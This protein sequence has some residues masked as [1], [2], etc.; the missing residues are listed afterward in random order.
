MAMA[1]VF[2]ANPYVGP[3]PFPP[4]ERIYGR[5]QEVDRLLNLLIAERIVLL[6]SPSGAGKTSLI[7]SALVPALM[8]AD[9]GVLPVMRVS[10]ETQGILG[11]SGGAVELPPAAPPD[12]VLSRLLSQQPSA[13]PL[14]AQPNSARAVN[15]YMLSALL[16]LEAGMPLDRQLPLTTLAGLTLAEYLHQRTSQA[17]R[18]SGIVLIFDQFE[19]ILTIDPAN[20]AAKVGFFRQVGEALRDR[21]YWALFALREDYLAGLDPY[22][23]PIPTR[24]ST[25]FR[26]DLLGVEAARVA[27]QRPSRRK[28]VDFTDAAVAKLVNDLRNIRVQ[29][30]DGSIDNQPG[31]YVEPVQ[32]QV[33]CY[34][35]WEQLARRSRLAATNIVAITEEDLELVGDVNS[36]LAGYY[37]ERVQLIAS[38]TGV[39]ERQ[40]RDWVDQKL[41][42]EQST[43]GQVLR[44]PEASQGLDNRAIALLIDWHLVRAE[45]RGDVIWF[46]LTHDRLIDP[47]RADNATWREA[48]LSA[49]QRQAAFWEQE[50]RPDGLLLRDAALASAE[51]W[52]ATAAIELTAVEQAFLKRCQE[53]RAAIARERRTTRIIRWLGIGATVLAIVALGAMLYALNRSAA[54]VRAEGAALAAR[55]TSEVRRN[56]ADRQRQVAL[57][58]QAQMLAAQAQTKQKD[59]PDLGL[60]LAIEAG[61]RDHGPFVESVLRHAVAQAFVHT[62][63]LT[64]TVTSAAFSPDGLRMLTTSSDGITELRSA[65]T[66]E[67][68]HQLTKKD[69]GSWRAVF[70]PDGK[71][72]IIGGTDGTAHVWDVDTWKELR[73]LRGHTKLIWGVAYSQD[74][75]RIA[76]A[77]GDGTARVWDAATGKE[78]RVLRGHDNVVIGVAFSADSQR[79]VT[80]SRD[81]TA[82]VWDVETGEQLTVLRGHT[83]VVTSAAFSPDS[84][85]IVTASGDGMARVWDAE[86]GTE[87]FV[88]SG[89]TEILFDVSFS[90]DG[91]RI[92]T[93]SGDKTARVWDAGSGAEITVL[94]GHTDQ[95][96]SA[97]FSPD[98]ARIMTASSDK[99]V[100]MWVVDVPILRGQT[101]EV[102]SAVFSPDSAR[103][104]TANADGTARVWD[105]GAGTELLVLR[106]HTEKISSAVFSPDGARVVTASADG[107]A[108][109]WEAATGKELLVLHGHTGEVSSTAFSPDSKRIVTAS[110]D[111]TA[112][113]WEAATGKELLVLHG[114]TGEVSSAAFS[115]DGARIVT[116]ASDDTA[117]VWDASSGIEQLAIREPSD[118]MWRATFSPDG[119]RIVTASGGN[120]ARI[121]DARDGTLLHVLTGHEKKVVSA[122]FSPDGRRIITGSLDKTACLWDVDTG[123]KLFK[124]DWH[125]DAVTS[126]AF[127]PD[128]RHMV[129]T[130]TDGTT[131]LYDAN[132]EDVLAA[133]KRLVT[134]ELT[135]TERETYFGASYSVGETDTAL[136]TP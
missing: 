96:T 136:G 45:K 65:R 118:G 134:R 117:R 62:Y 94:R 79:I 124:L 108:R 60:L 69:D 49:L 23:R 91:K 133:A 63:E 85:Q 4:D 101:Q 73:V 25:N 132:F 47:I 24:F 27:I 37:A 10:T 29:R 48:N 14:S 130:S 72:F 13:A 129:T 100:R 42:S 11:T 8:A 28:Q 36:A 54:A 103:I 1:P 39:S 89:H 102:I 67:H 3:R 17:D 105:V 19:E 6:Y 31:P 135:R 58:S 122:V 113:V 61:R 52:A 87:L 55:A 120:T 51:V 50:K 38:T 107:T 57:A 20:Q 71:R 81:S 99:T 93:A 33:V 119:A 112:R 80:T 12:D 98:G 76:T 121:W 74:G 46:E 88:L 35:L 109:V 59:D 2:P 64:G 16:S 115:S 126:A 66:G 9:F 15:R 21:H 97:V 68:I 86:R 40:I 78:L 123:E 22:L 7:Q 77:S 75:K 111:G 53:V 44:G 34:R 128:G 114:H 104:V 32:L 92:V 106:G 84:K 83:K 5:D 82:Q 110:A 95:V 127:S 43:R 116:A 30:P 70:S 26:L 56:E 41:I 90:P 18:A 131:R 125:D